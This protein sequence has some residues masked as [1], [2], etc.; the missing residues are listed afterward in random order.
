MNIFC[1]RAGLYRR[2]LVVG[3]CVGLVA[4]SG[5][6]PN[7]TPPAGWGHL[8]NA[9]AEILAQEALGS[10]NLNR[11]IV[12]ARR[13]AFKST[14]TEVGAH[15]MID[16]WYSDGSGRLVQV[17]WDIVQKDWLADF[18]STTRPYKHSYVHFVVRG[19]PML[20]STGRILL[21]EFYGGEVYL[22]EMVLRWDGTRWQ[23]ESIREIP[24]PLPDRD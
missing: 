24:W 16:A 23:K 19:T 2:V 11:Y 6:A 9:A 20:D 22:A 5:Q 3:V 10:G 12:Y 14:G 8:P 21:T 7:P 15:N 17:T 13:D 4:C 1:G 18:N